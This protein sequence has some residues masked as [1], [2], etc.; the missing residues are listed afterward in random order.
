MVIA[1]MGINLVIVEGRIIR[2]TFNFNLH[3]KAQNAQFHIQFIR[4]K[5]CANETTEILQHLF[6]IFAL[7]FLIV[8]ML[9][10]ST[11]NI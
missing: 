11:Q 6:E 9:M 7:E 4:Q 8:M 3:G 2:V 10:S 5:S 1:Q